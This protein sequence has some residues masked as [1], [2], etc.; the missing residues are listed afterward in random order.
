MAQDVLEQTKMTYQDIR[1]N[2]IQGCMKYKAY[3]DRRRKASKLKEKDYVY[4]LQPEP[5]HQGSKI[6]FTELRWLGA[7]NIEKALPG[8]NNSVRQAGTEKTQLPHCMIILQIIPL[9]PL[10]YVQTRQQG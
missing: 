1:K 8:S 2:A 7:H 10:L 6:L 3:H 4:A 9:Q 5:Q